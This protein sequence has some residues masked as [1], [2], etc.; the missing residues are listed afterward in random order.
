MTGN[1]I[2]YLLKLLIIMSVVGLWPIKSVFS[3]S[4]ENRPKDLQHNIIEIF[5]N[6]NGTS[7][8]ELGINCPVYLEVVIQNIGLFKKV[9]LD[10]LKRLEPK[11][12]K[13]GE[14][15]DLNINLRFLSIKNVPDSKFYSQRQVSIFWLVEQPLLP[16]EYKVSL[17]SEKSLRNANYHIT[18]GLIKIT[19]STSPIGLCKGYQRRI[20]ALKGRYKEALAGIEKEMRNNPEDVLLAL[21]KIE[22][23]IEL[24][25]TQEAR[26]ILFKIY[27]KYQKENRVPP[28]FFY[29]FLLAI[30][31]VEGKKNF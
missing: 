31:E 12:S 24:K 2:G 9:G 28:C 25:K 30:Q 27:D 21:E 15:N 13:A 19:S 3:G 23:L 17:K 7:M 1:S 16:G 11:I 29:Q 14:D 4:E 26:D 6:P 8:V 18:P 5:I 10:E 22:F 20:L